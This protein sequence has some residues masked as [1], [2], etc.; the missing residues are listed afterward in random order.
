MNQKSG[1]LIKWFDVPFDFLSDFYFRRYLKRIGWK[2]GNTAQDNQ[3]TILLSFV[4]VVNSNKI[5]AIVALKRHRRLCVYSTGH[6]QTHKCLHTSSTSSEQVKL[7]ARNKNKSPIESHFMHGYVICDCNDCNTHSICR[8]W[9]VFVKSTNVVQYERSTSGTRDDFVFCQLGNTK[10]D[11]RIY[12][13]R[14]ISV[15]II[16]YRK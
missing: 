1:M 9:I 10:N 4:L 13:N 6:T 16:R 11:F 2:C 15:I 3:P 7:R 5:H 12:L 14:Q 8:N